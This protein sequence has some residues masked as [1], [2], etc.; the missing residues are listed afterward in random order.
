MT[1]FLRRVPT[2]LLVLLVVCLAEALAWC[3]VLPPL[4]GP[5]ETS[6]VAYVQKIAEARTIPWGIGGRRGDEAKPYSTELTRASQV[7]G[8]EALRGNRSARPQGTSIDERIWGEREATFGREQRADGGHT[9][10]LLNP[11]AYYVYEAVVYAATSPLS[12]FDQIFFL[13]LANIPFLLLTVVFVWLIAGELLGRRRWLQTLAAG[14]VALQPQLVHLT[15]VVNPDVALSAVSSAALYLMIVILRR[16]LTRPRTLGLIALCAAAGLTHGRGLAL[17]APALLTLA[18]A[19]WKARH[20]GERPTWRTALA[21]AGGA[22]LLAVPAFVVFT[23]R[24]DVGVDSVRRLGS[25]L[26][27]FYLPRPDWM[28][29]VGPDYGLREVLVERLFGGFAQLE[30]GFSPALND[31]VWLGLI[32]V[33][34]SAATALVLHR[35]WLHTSWDVAAVL[36]AACLATLGLLHAVAFRGLTAAGDPII[37]GR[38]LLPLAALYGL[39]VALSVAWLPRRWGVALGGA[40][41][42]VLALLELGAM[43]LTVERFYA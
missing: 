32:A 37:T 18:L 4:Q 19:V 8:V 7:G 10:A 6:H 12:I 11:P 3:V 17:V 29:H 16:G 43:G 26:W 5:D 25:Y 40:L 28:T 30:I 14:A 23:L 42:G 2:P 36:V 15:A 38:Y 31:A 20:P 22:A 21:L 35:G 27:Q 9:S 24:G 39:A 33:A 34:L 1:R 41:L 13:R